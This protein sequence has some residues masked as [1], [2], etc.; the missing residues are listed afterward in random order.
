MACRLAMP[1]IPPLW[2][3]HPAFSVTHIADSPASSGKESIHTPADQPH[4]RYDIMNRLFIKLTKYTPVIS[5]ALVIA[6]VAVIHHEI[7]LYHWQEIKAAVSSMPLTLLLGMGACTLLGYLSLSL[8]DYLALEYAG[9]KLPWYKILLA[10]FLGYAISNNIGHALV[11]GGSLRLRLYTGWGVS[12][13]SVA[14]VILFCSITYL[15]GAITLMVGTYTALSGQALTALNLPD[16]QITGI[17]MSTGASAL[18]VWWG[19]ILFYRKDITIR[20]FTLSPPGGSLALRQTLAALLDLLLASV[21]LYLPLTHFIE[22][23]F[24]T[25]LMI[26]I[27]AQL[28]GL[29]SQVPGGIGVFEGSFMFLASGH[30]PASQIL[31]ALITYRAV[32]YLLPLLFAGLILTLYELKPHKWLAKNTEIKAILDSLEPAIPQLFSLLLLLGGCVLLISGSTPAVAERLQWLHYILPL[33]LIEF[34]HLLASMAGVMLLFLSRAVHQRMDAA[35]YATIVML[36]LGALA[37]LAKGWDFEEAT[38][39]TLLLLL[40]LPA[41]KH[42]YR[43]SSLL[44]VDLPVSW[45]AL[46]ILSIGLSAWL[47]F[48]SFKHVEYSNQL[49]WQFSLHGDAPRFLRSLVAV[50]VLASGLILYRLLTHTTSTLALPDQAMLDRAA[51]LAGKAPNTMPHLALLG[52]K[53]LLWSESG[54]SFLMFATT[55]KI[56]VAMGDAVG[57]PDEY[58]ELAWK[59]REMADQ[60]AANIAFYQVGQHHLPLYLDFGLSLL[61]LGEEA[62]VPLQGFSLE[63]RQRQNLR[64]A[65]NKITRQGISFTIVPAADVT[66]I[67]PDLRTISDRWMQTKQAREKRFSLGFFDTDYLRRCDIA[68]AMKDG[69]PLAFANIWKTDGR[70]ELSIDLMRYT[71]DAPNGVMEYLMVSLMLWGKEEGYQWFNLGMAPLSGLRSHPLAPV[72]QRIGHSIFRFGGEFYN[73]EGLYHYKEKFDP[74]WQ[75]RYLAAPSGLKVASTL[76]SVTGLISGGIEGAIR[77]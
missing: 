14:K 49:W 60:H 30:Y 31:A 4:Q 44:A 3:Y 15:I 43:K 2:R 52:D 55:P 27:L 37:S 58:D 48:F 9:E 8:Y 34:S 17:V 64:H 36:V 39:L 45:V 11:S 20:G 5:I 77:K 72:W 68:V 76:L 56:W 24:S 53:H 33:P 13:V 42:F 38:I 7:A 6:A 59:F 28:T 74:D 22:I 19:I 69:S 51:V 35:Y 40:F 32:Y 47:G 10:S 12:A 66:A 65:Y 46:V 57:N 61:K 16:R 71:P 21:V 73:F 29:F 54:N 70:E 67:L 18:L 75:P 63:G 62:R 41:H 26:Y 50:S 1:T 23:P 25:F